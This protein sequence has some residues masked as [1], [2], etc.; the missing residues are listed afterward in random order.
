MK[1]PDLTRLNFL[2]IALVNDPANY[3]RLVA[4]MNSLTPEFEKARS[5]LIDAFSNSLDLPQVIQD[6]KSNPDE[7]VQQAGKSLAWACESVRMQKE[8]GR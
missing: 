5:A 1:E 8:W 3:E 4:R 2:A 6:L 7:N